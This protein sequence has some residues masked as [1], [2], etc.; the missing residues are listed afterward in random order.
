MADDLRGFDEAPEESFQPLI[1]PNEYEAHCIKYKEF[2]QHGSR[3]KICLEWNFFL[4]GME[5]I[6]L[7]QYFNMAHKKFKEY[8]YY[9]WNWVIANNGN[10]PLRRTRQYMSPKIFVDVIAIVRVDTVIA[11]FPDKTEKPPQFN[12]SK[13]SFIKRLTHSNSKAGGKK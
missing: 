10:K 13:V 7:P 4:S 11:K 6:V 1:E 5:D 3:P 9:Y 12:Y 8:A 2:R